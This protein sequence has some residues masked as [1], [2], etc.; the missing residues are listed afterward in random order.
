MQRSYFLHTFSHGQR[1]CDHHAGDRRG[2]FPFQMD[3]YHRGGGKGWGFIAIFYNLCTLLVPLPF[4]LSVHCCSL[5]TNYLGL[6]GIWSSIWK[7]LGENVN[8]DS[9]CFL[10]DLSFMSTLSLLSRFSPF[11][12]VKYILFFIFAYCAIFPTL[13]PIY[14][15]FSNVSNLKFG[16]LECHIMSDKVTYLKSPLDPQGCT[17]NISGKYPQKVSVTSLTRTY[18]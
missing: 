17:R 14:F 6:I 9:S 13:T 12:C 16:K 7:C 4:L 2:I 15:T 3:G 11:C 8:H 5:T 10:V 1:Q 18:I